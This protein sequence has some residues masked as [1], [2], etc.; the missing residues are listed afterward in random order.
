[1][2]NFRRKNRVGCETTILGRRGQG[3]PVGSAWAPALA[4]D[5]VD[6]V[7]DF[8]DIRV[9]FDKDDLRER[10]ARLETLLEHARATACEQKRWNEQLHDTQYRMGVQIGRLQEENESLRAE[11][12]A[13]KA[14]DKAA[15]LVK[16]LDDALCC[17][18]SMALFE[19][20][21]VSKVSGHS[22]SREHIEKWLLKNSHCP[23]TRQKM[24]QKHLVPNYALAGVVDAF[25]A[26]QARQPKQL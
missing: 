24:A 19:D 10:V 17:P 20:P 1:M 12:L 26:H 3:R 18:I 4:A 7:R 23:Q 6:S 9:E 8:H 5:S 25:R 13:A 21:V 15:K 14:A 16:D 2:F 11:L 22:Y